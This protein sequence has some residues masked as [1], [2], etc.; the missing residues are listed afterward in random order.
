MG[1]LQQHDIALPLKKFCLQVRGMFLGFKIW[2]GKPMITQGYSFTFKKLFL[3]PSLG[4]SALW[5][6]T[7]CWLAWNC[8]CTSWLET[9]SNTVQIGIIVFK[10][11]QH[12]WVI[13]SAELEKKMIVCNRQYFSVAFTVHVLYDRSVWTPYKQH[14]TLSAS[15][16]RIAS[17]PLVGTSSTLRKENRTVRKVGI[18]LPLFVLFFCWQL[19]VTVFLCCVL[20]VYV[21]CGY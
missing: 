13:S 12:I 18:F 2:N 1:S 9:L 10:A 5:I 19:G 20:K 16:V 21:N 7:L 11:S 4:Q 8:S 15:C 14:G 17:S 3:P 6:C